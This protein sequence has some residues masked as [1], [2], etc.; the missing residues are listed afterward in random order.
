ME[1]KVEINFALLHNLLVSVAGVLF[2]CFLDVVGINVTGLSTI[3]REN[4]DNSILGDV[5]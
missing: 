3:V 4:F 1:S 2:V 5:S